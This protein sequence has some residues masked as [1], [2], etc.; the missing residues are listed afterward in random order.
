MGKRKKAAQNIVK[1]DVGD[2]AFEKG[3]ILPVLVQHSSRD[4]RRIE[5]TVHKV[6]TPRPNPP[7][8]SYDPSPVFED[9]EGCVSPDAD[10]L[11]GELDDFENVRS[12]PL[13]SRCIITPILATVDPFTNLVYRTR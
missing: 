2:F 7:P 8:P 4:G 11:A 10:N 9:V 1:L 12:C 13:S 6:P 5:Q 3:E